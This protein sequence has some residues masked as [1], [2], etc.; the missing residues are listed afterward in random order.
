MASAARDASHT[1]PRERA[2]PQQNASWRSSL[3]PLDAPA[4]AIRDLVALRAPFAGARGVLRVVIEH[5]VALRAG[6]RGIGLIPP[7][8]H[9]DVEILALD[10]CQVPESVAHVDPDHD[11][12]S[13]LRC[14]PGH[15][16][17]IHCPTVTCASQRTHL[18]RPSGKVGT[19]KVISCLTS[20]P[21][22]WPPPAAAPPAGAGPRAAR[23]RGRSDAVGGRHSPLPPGPPGPAPPPPG[24]R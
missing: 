8:V 24:R 23:A 17:R 13:C 11:G 21:R 6:R 18:A 14:F 4:R 10:A 20:S 5:P 12:S 3:V 2:G 9:V 7:F 15:V 19:L 1:S 16:S 22:S